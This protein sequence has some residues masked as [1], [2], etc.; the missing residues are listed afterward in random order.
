V[1]DVIGMMSSFKWMSEALI[2]YLNRDESKAPTPPEAPPHA[3]ID[4]GSIHRELEKVKFLELFGAS[5][6]AASRYGWRTWKCDFHFT[7][8]PPT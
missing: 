5:D 8:I 2:I 7:T 4:T 1:G 6:D 3:S